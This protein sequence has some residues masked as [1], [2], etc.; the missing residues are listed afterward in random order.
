MSFS[1][2]QKTT[3]PIPK[4]ETLNYKPNFCFD[5]PIVKNEFVLNFKMFTLLNEKVIKS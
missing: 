5:A 1:A 2:V 3:K 4:T